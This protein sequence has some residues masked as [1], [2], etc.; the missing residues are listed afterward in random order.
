MDDETTVEL[1]PRG[2]RLRIAQI[3][4]PWFTV[5]PRNY[6]GIERVV[7]ILADGLAAR[8]HEVTLFAPAGSQSCGSRVIE[9]MPPM[10]E[11]IG[12]SAVGTAHTV[13]SY[14]DTDRFDVIHD[15]TVVGL[16]ASPFIPQPVV[17]T[18]HGAVLPDVE[19]LYANLPRNVHL[20]AISESQRRT[21]PEGVPQSLIYNAVDLTGYEWSDQ[22]GDYLLFVGRASVEKGPLA[23]IEIA[24]RVGMPLRMLLKV[25]EPPE[26]EYFELI[27]EHVRGSSDVELELGV[28]ELAKRDAFR[29]AYATLFPIAWEEPF[30][31]VMIESM[32]AGTPVIGFRRG[33]VPEVICHGETGFICD[34]IDEAVAAV[35]VIQT[36]DRAKSRARVEERFSARAAVDAH[37]ELYRALALRKSD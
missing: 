13:L 10:Y 25:E 12:S 31:L 17:H 27:K 8:G 14:A 23:A 20:V 34:D 21:L 7:A 37:E 26:K 24:R 16:A 30:G 6:G 5:P 36:L 29:G 28:M 35:P 15:H 9:T 2:E 18:V 11:F 19:L 32:A 1:L 4:P 3:A 22:P 33:S